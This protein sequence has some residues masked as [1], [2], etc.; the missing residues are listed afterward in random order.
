MTFHTYTKWK[1]ESQNIK[2]FIQR[3]G[4]RRL[5]NRRQKKSLQRLN[6]KYETVY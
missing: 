6:W 2:D 3:M 1:Y 4:Y 5:D